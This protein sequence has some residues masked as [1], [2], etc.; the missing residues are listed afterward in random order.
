MLVWSL[1]SLVTLMYSNISTGYCIISGDS[2]CGAVCFLRE[3]VE[4][5]TKKEETKETDP[6]TSIDV[7][8]W[9]WCQNFTCNTWALYVFHNTVE[10]KSQRVWY[11]IQSSENLLKTR[12]VKW[13]IYNVQVLAI[14]DTII[15]TFSPQ[16]SNKQTWLWWCF[17]R[18]SESSY[19]KT[20]FMLSYSHT[21]LT[22]DLY[23][24]MQ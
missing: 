7:V 19:W 14:W 17:Q 3:W 1:A 6:Q 15:A 16:A 21:N 9:N 20:S 12:Q 13:R 10:E 24:L 23:T 18:Y 4:I 8:A 11:C 22:Y 5:E 2:H